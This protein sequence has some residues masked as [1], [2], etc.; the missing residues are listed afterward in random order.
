[1]LNVFVFVS[2]FGSLVGKL[3]QKGSS[4]L[5]LSLPFSLYCILYICNLLNLKKKLRGKGGYFSLL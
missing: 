2:T 5:S 3:V 1:V 4:E